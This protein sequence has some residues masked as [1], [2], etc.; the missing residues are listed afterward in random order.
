MKKSKTI[1]IRIPVDI[2]DSGIE[3]VISGDKAKIIDKINKQRGT[4]Y[5]VE[6]EYEGICIRS[7]EYEPMIL[8]EKIPET[9]VEIG[10]LAHEIFHAVVGILNYV[11]IMLDPTTEEVWSNLIGYI[12]KEFFERMNKH[13]KRVQK[14][15]RKSAK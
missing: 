2:F 1:R 15:S 8:L 4:D 14:R 7:S 13:E 9:T 5:D 12:T 6:E 10:T 3:F 11:G